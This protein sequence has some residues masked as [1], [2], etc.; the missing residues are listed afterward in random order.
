MCK[1]FFW[2][3]VHTWKIC[4]WKNRDIKALALELYKWNIKKAT[5]KTTK[6][7]T[8]FSALSCIAL[9]LFNSVVVV[10]AFVVV[11]IF[12]KEWMTGWMTAMKWM[13]ECRCHTHTTNILKNMPSLTWLKRF[14]ENVEKKMQKKYKKRF[15]MESKKNATSF[16]RTSFFI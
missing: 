13:K 9:F 3:T 12:V 16:L 10:V 15:V 7:K 6:T 5:T 8:V 11:I 4:T 2:Q 1:N 14:L